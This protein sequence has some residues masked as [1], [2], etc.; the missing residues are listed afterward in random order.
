MLVSLATVGG[1]YSHRVCVL[2]H[3]GRYLPVHL[4][5]A[6]RYPRRCIAHIC[7]GG[8]GVCDVFE[9]VYILCACVCVERENEGEKE[10]VCARVERRER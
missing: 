4:S 8:V 7:Q 9:K 5:D 10:R 6:L 3:L 1:T 2:R